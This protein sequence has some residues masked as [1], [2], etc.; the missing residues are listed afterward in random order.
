MKATRSA[1]ASAFAFFL[2]LFVFAASPP[3]FAQDAIDTTK[4]AR[5]PNSKEL[6]A[7]P[8]ST[9]YTTSLSVPEALTA[10]STL[11]VNEKWQPYEQAFA[12]Q[13]TTA[14]LAIVNFKKD[15]ELLSVMITPAPAQ[16]NA[17]GVSYT[18]LV[19]GHDLPFP[20]NASAIKY[21]PTRPYLSCLSAA[22]PESLSLEMRKGLQE[23]GWQPWS[24]KDAKRVADGDQKTDGGGV[25]AYYVHASEPS[26]HLSIGK[27]EDGQTTLTIEA[28]SAE[29]LASV[30]KSPSDSK[31][32]AKEP[33]TKAE[34]APQ[35][36]ADA[37]KT[38]DQMDDLAGQIM[39]Q[40]RS[41]IDDALSGIGK[42]GAK[43][44][45]KTASDAGS[46]L[47]AMAS[48]DV[49]AAIPV[50]LPLGSED[51]SFDSEQLEFSNSASVARVAAFYRSA[52]KEK[53][54]KER[55]T[56]INKPNMVVLQFDKSGSSAEFTI[57]RMGDH[58]QVTGTG[59]AFEAAATKSDGEEAQA[60]A[61]AD[62]EKKSITADQLQPDEAAGLPVPK[63][64][65][66]KGSE[67]TM[68]RVSALAEVEAPL[69]AVLEFYRRELGKRTDWQM[70]NEATDSSGSA[71]VQ[72]ATPEGPAVLTLTEKSGTTSIVLLV[73]KKKEAQASGLMPK[74]G[75]VRILIGNIL[76]KD[77]EISFAKKTIKVGA[78]KGAKAPDGPTLEIKPGSYAVNVKSP[79]LNASPET[80]TVGADEIWGLMIG[81]GGI[82]ALPMY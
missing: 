3:A 15:R 69:Q 56:P 32:E 29:V 48:N 4:I 7:F 14:N 58:T 34:Q 9:S 42:P 28:I 16:N 55:K 35:A 52:L 17:T 49:D 11:L 33:E 39:D 31:V 50:P 1:I 64:S 61:S 23:R 46:P 38:P 20:N 40:A 18:A 74:P 5:L 41:A 66:S 72:Y 6:F 73:R 63:Q 54:W 10:L 37:A 27:R 12:S 78:G 24:P 8:Q 70:Q 21:D 43:K 53:G 76:E 62:D 47:A 79:G 60:G 25:T 45:S 30:G 13:S 22:E 77:A 51:I 81:P 26:L 68:F 59:A 57:M 44:S 36:D 19:P 2:T 80:I 65:T 71:R 82:L 67:K 75:Q